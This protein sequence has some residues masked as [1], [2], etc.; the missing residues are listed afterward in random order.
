MLFILQKLRIV[1]IADVIFLSLVVRIMNKTEIKIIDEQ[2]TYE[3]PPICRLN[4][5]CLINIFKF[6]PIKDRVFVERGIVFFKLIS[7]FRKSRFDW[8]LNFL[9][10][11]CTSKR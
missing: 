1:F 5:D 11:L 10:I 9:Q 8:K 7:I 3:D 6:L 2:I 4:D